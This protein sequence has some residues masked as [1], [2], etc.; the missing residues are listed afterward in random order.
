[1]EEETTAGEQ[2]G[3]NSFVYVHVLKTVCNRPGVLV[4]LLMRIWLLTHTPPLLKLNIGARVF[5]AASY[6]KSYVASVYLLSRP[7]DPP[8]RVRGRGLMAATSQQKVF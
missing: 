1:M 8:S 2:D 3:V 4:T 5:G 6:N 7:A